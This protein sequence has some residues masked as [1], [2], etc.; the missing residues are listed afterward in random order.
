MRRNRTSRITAGLCFVIALGLVPITFLGV[1]DARADESLQWD[2]DLTYRLDSENGSIVLVS[3]ITV[4]NRQRNSTRGNTIIQYYFD[5]IGIYVPV[6]AEGLAVTSGGSALDFEVMEPEDEEAEGLDLIEIRLPRRLFYN[7]SSDV[8]VEYYIPSHEPRSD[9]MFRVNPAYASF[10][11]WAWGDPGRVDV[12][13]IVDEGFEVTAT[14]STYEV[15]RDG[16]DVIYTATDIDDPDEWLMFFTAR[17]D[18]RLETETVSLGEF[19]ILVKSWPG[20]TFWRDEVEA[21]V[22]DGAPVL[23]ELVGLEWQVDD[24]LTVRE[25]IEPTVLGYGGWYLDTSELVEIGEY[26]DPQL[27]LHEIGHTWFNEDLFQER[28][29]TEGL[30]DEFAAATVEAIGETSFYEPVA[31]ASN[32]PY[33]FALNDWAEP[34]EFDRREEKFE[35]YGYETSWWIMHRLAEEIEVDGLSAVVGAAHADEIAYHQHSAIRMRK[36]KSATP[37][38]TKMAWG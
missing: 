31:P 28:W 11:V 38:A 33:G 32:G 25:S 27:V 16:S 14:G 24:D 13:V 6:E 29:I 1:G 7:R 35:E 18:A 4:T 20:D 23:Q 37:N 9:S 15:S 17:N 36:M 8:R 22:T 2:T 10:G 5:R 30:A 26:V 19:E 34:T 3:D 21:S 12:S